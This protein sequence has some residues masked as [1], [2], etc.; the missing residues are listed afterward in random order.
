MLVLDTHTALWWTLEPD[1]LGRKVAARIKREDQLGIP[2]IVFWETSLLV[3]KGRLSLEMGAPDWARKL[4]TIPRVVPL[5]LTM[6][7]G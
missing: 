5:P 6:E 3:R 1:R 4:C 2:S 7:I